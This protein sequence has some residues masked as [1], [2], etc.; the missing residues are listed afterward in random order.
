MARYLMMTEEQKEIV[1]LIDQVM[2]K[3]Y[4]PKR[5]E[6]EKAGDF[7]ME[8]FD[9]LYEVG[10]YGLEVPEEYGGMGADTVTQC[11]V[12]EELG[13]FDAGFAFSFRLGSSPYGVVERATTD[14][15]MRKYVADM[16]MS[17]KIGATCITEADA[18]SEVPA[19]RTTAVKDGDEW[20]INGTKCFITNGG[21][22][23]FFIV[24]AYTNKELGGKGISLFLVERD[25]GVTTGKTEDKMGLKMSNTS[26]VIFDNVRVPADHLLGA[27]GTGYKTILK[28]LDR[29]RAVNMA[30]VVGLAQSALDYSVKYAKERQTFG[31]PIIKHQGFNF[32]LADMEIKVQAARAMIMYAALA[33]DQGL[34]MGT[35]CSATKVF[36]SEA[37]MQVTIDAVQA[38]GGY[39]Y[40][41][42][43][44]VEKL[45]RD[46]KIFSIFEGTNQIQRMIIGG[47][48]ERN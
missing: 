45:M 35:L 5:D 8:L 2:T 33:Y 24:A 42:E 10:L 11:V 44:P 7:P 6:Y 48:L 28:G 14:P 23:D 12:N 34:P 13:K 30:F 19:I 27:E 31:K 29:A 22:A 41:K 16:I 4:L 20:V 18:G 39:G 43:Y 32:M 46:A 9:K 17:G 25:R 15:G 47:I 1:D 3:E 40:M 26:E 38:F 36:S 37:C 21:I